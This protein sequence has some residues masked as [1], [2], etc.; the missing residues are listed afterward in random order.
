MVACDFC[1][2]NF[3]TKKAVYDGKTIF[4]PWAFM[5]EFHAEIYGVKSYLKK[6]ETDEEKDESI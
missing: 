1:A 5:C 4:G 2:H 6:L 3:I